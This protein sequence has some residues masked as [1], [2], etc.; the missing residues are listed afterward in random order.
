MNTL[1]IA[2]ALLVA[3]AASGCSKEKLNELVDQEKETATS[4]A[5]DVSSE[6]KSATEEA[7]AKVEATTQQVAETAG[8]VNGIG[9]TTGKGM[10]TLDSPTEF[11]ASY[12]QLIAINPGRPAVL[13]IS[14]SK[15]GD[16]ETFPAFLLQAN[17][18]AAGDLNALAGQ[19]VSARLFAQKEAGGTIWFSPD[20]QPVPVSIAIDQGK[21]TA[22][23]ENASVMNSSS[24]Q[25]TAVSGIFECALHP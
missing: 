19:T 24:S 25:E 20:D 14:S 1:R 16:D 11:A 7:V 6:V 5:S 3:S 4:V 18:S 9:D 21:V 8:D 2:C 23:I 15:D 22:R 10:M 12:V 17:L 13:K